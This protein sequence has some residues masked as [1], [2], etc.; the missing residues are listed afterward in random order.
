MERIDQ[1]NP[2]RLLWS[3][4]DR[5]LSL[6]EVARKAGIAV[7]T[8][9]KVV[10]GEIGLTFKQL[11]ALADLLGRGVLF[12]LE[13]GPVNEKTVHSPQF[14]TLA[15]QKP[16]MS[17]EVKGLIERVSRVREVYLDLMDEDEDRPIYDPPEMKNKNAAQA[18]TIARRWLRI[19]GKQRQT[20]SLY[21]SAVEARGV[22]VFLSTG[23]AGRWKFPKSSSVAGFSL[24][25]PECPVI[26]IRKHR[27]PAR[28]VFTLMHELGHL[29]MHRASVIDEEADFYAHRGREREANAFAGHLLVPDGVLSRIRDESRPDEPAGYVEWLKKPSTH[30][31]VSTETILRRLLD[32]RRLSQE[33]YKAFRKYMNSLPE[34]VVETAVRWRDREPV[35]LFG[36]HYVRSVLGAVQSKQISLSKASGYLDNLKIPDIHKL[37]KH[38]AGL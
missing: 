10:A 3:V 21:R 6:P 9:E 27:A 19:D 20:F 14:R 28:Q 5:G 16:N 24:Y 26:A 4:N 22:M 38:L 32:T 23:Y 17:G 8:L 25:F 29:L 18:A 34:P 30:L 37:E 1:I 33:D 31:G 12:F 11:K 36:D 7:K 35:H 13:S 15:N 2:E